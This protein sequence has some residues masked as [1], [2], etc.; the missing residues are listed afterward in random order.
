MTIRRACAGCGRVTAQTPCSSCR[1]TYKPL[2]HDD[3]E[4]RR[5]R[6]IVLG[7]AKRCAITGREATADDPLTADHIVPLS[8]GGTHQLDN[9]RPVLRSVNSGRA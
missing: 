7:N 5:N 9:L 6:H 3:A 8:Q 4:Y 2:R 1:G